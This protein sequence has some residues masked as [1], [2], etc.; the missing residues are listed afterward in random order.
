MGLGYFSSPILRIVR[1]SAS[2]MSVNHFQLENFWD[3]SAKCGVFF[4]MPD[5]LILGSIQYGFSLTNAFT[6]FRKT[7]SLYSYEVIK[8]TISI[9]FRSIAG[10]IVGFSQDSKN[11]RDNGP[12]LHSGL[13]LRPSLEYPYWGGYE[14]GLSPWSSRHRTTSAVLTVMHR[15]WVGYSF[16]NSPGDR[17]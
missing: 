10:F 1:I 5:S 4:C 8:G 17:K 11:Q 9:R 14:I 15:F 16:Q 2:T 6:F 3:H 13:E 7:D 12:T